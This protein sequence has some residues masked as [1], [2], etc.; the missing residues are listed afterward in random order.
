MKGTISPKVRVQDIAAI[1]EE[2]EQ[3]QSILD[4]ITDE[5][6]ARMKLHAVRTSAT[7]DTMRVSYDTSN[8]RILVAHYVDSDNFY[9]IQADSTGVYYYK[10]D[11]G[12]GSVV[13]LATDRGGTGATTPN[14]ALQNLGIAYKVND[15]V[16]VTNLQT[17]GYISSSTTEIG[18]TV[19]PPKFMN[20]ISTVTLTSLQAIIRTTAGGYINNNNA[21]FIQ[22]VNASGYTVSAAK[23]SN[24][25]FRVTIKKSS[26]FTNVT[27]NTPVSIHFTYTAKF[28]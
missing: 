3:R 13:P 21:S 28:T 14:A 23:A 11:N 7:D 2:L 25:A 17:V 8:S 6:E 1:Q 16:T 12:T 4:G 27:N 19:Y 5:A 9:Q 24:N 20:A 10:R 18:F 26:A 15:T 22:Y